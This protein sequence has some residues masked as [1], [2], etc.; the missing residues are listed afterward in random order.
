MSGPR[1]PTD[2]SP[3]GVA[4]DGKTKD[5]QIYQ[6]ISDAILGYRLAPGAKLPEDSLA[7]TFGV[8]RTIIRKVLLNLTHSG[9]VTSTPNRGSRVAHPTAKEG[10]EVF[11][12]RRL[13]EV[14]A[15]PLV[16]ENLTDETLKEL[17]TLDKAQK[18]AQVA[19]DHHNAIQLSGKFHESIIAVTDNKILTEF[20]RNLISQSSLIVAVY[21]STQPLLSS[22]IGHSELLDLIEAKQVS[23]SQEWMDT[24]LQEVEA[25]LEFTPKKDDAINF[26][27]VFF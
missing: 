14:A 24:H 12:S 19:S 16:I 22:C 7:E 3:K 1:T 17:K 20:V 2:S 18:S 13:V 8:S 27:K 9:L 5:I 26:S 23:E 15:I 21:G 11:A 25:T 10:K 4:A 6:S